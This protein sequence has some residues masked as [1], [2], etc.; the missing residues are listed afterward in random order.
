[1]T[2]S[3]SVVPRASAVARRA[4]P[5]EVL[6]DAQRAPQ[7]DAKGKADLRKCL[8]NCT[9]LL[10]IA[11]RDCQARADEAAALRAKAEDYDRL[12]IAMDSVREELDALLASTSWRLTAP[13]R[14]LIERLRG[15][16]S[17]AGRT[18]WKLAA[19]SG[20][21][22]QR[23]E[24]PPIA[25]EVEAPKAF[26]EPWP[27]G[28]PRVTVLVKRLRTD[29]IDAGAASAAVLAAAMAKHQRA[30]LRIISRLSPPEPQ[31]FD[32]LMAQHGLSY[33]D[34][35][36]CDWLTPTGRGPVIGVTVGER[37]VVGSWEDATLAL[38]LVSADRMVYVIDQAEVPALIGDGTGTDRRLRDMVGARGP[39]LV[40]TDA[41]VSD[42]LRRAGLFGERDAG[43]SACLLPSSPL[44]PDWQ[45][46]AAHLLEGALSG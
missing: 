11:E 32:E 5:V 24:G 14:A 30:P 23:S 12:A 28:P 37:V 18:T 8:A 20:Q 36:S 1:M 45:R 16:R 2:E 25:S 22:S 26:P 9:R 31:A 43:A 39:A 13:L 38:E 29:A 44:G 34:N 4:I 46:I 33:D 21:K 3:D 6:R 15:S 10:A 41:G 35:L 40:F 27:D 19:V 7:T 42:E 17:R